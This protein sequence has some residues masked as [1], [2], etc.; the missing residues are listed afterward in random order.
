MAQ[1]A[2]CS[3]VPALSVIPL[4]YPGGPPHLFCL[5]SSQVA[6]KKTTESNKAAAALKG[7]NS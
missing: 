3:C 2:A 4:G 7:R 6:A 5:N 1:G